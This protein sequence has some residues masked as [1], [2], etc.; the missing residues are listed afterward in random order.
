M[1]CSKQRTLI[2]SNLYHPGQLVTLGLT[3]RGKKSASTNVSQDFNSEPERHQSAWNFQSVQL[4]KLFHVIPSIC[5]SCP[6]IQKVFPVLSFLA[7]DFFK[8][9]LTTKNSFFFSLFF[10][11]DKKGFSSKT[12]Y[13]AF[14]FMS[15]SGHELKRALPF[16]AVRRTGVLE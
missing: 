10:F 5:L 7:S 9:I 4:P 3:V 16:A 2:Q 14:A 12:S 6:V 13:F 15:Q 8:S 1:N 11:L